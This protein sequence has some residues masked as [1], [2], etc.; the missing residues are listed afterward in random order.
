MTIIDR[1][2]LRQYVQT[3]VICY[4]SLTGLYVVFDAFTNI[5]EFLRAAPDGGGLFRLMGSY[6][7]YRAVFLFDR[8][9]GILVLCA[10]MFTVTWIQRNNE[11][12]ALLA[13]GVPKLRVIAPVVAACAVTTLSAAA[14]RELVIPRFREELSRPTNDLLGERAQEFN[15]QFDNRTDIIIGGRAAFADGRRIAEPR[16]LLPDALAHYGNQL[17]AR[18]AFYHPPRDDRPGGYLL[19]RVSRPEG[20]DQRPSLSLGE[21]PVILTPYDTPWL[22]AG[23]CFVVSGL[24][25]EQLTAGRGWREF[26]STGQ[27]IA[28]LRNPSLGFGADVRVAVHSRFVQPLLDMTLLFLGLPLV[29]ARNSRNIFAAIGMCMAVASGFVLVVLACQ[30]LGASYAVSPALAAWLPLILFVP[31]AVVMFDR[32]LE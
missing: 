28:S 1:Y 10:A 8:L 17:V 18:E 11:M 20:L 6:Y 21:R 5:E 25:F 32:I 30:Y 31:P 14:N 27:L 15:Q 9:A 2:L 12:T 19:V 3:L 23:E 24:T 16:L 7:G 29:L 22:E 26:A 4:V 13:A